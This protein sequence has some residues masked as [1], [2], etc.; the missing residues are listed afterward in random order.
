MT[1]L[2]KVLTLLPELIK[3]AQ[4]I[5]RARDKQVDGS[6]MSR[7]ELKEQLQL[8]KK[9]IDE[10]DEKLLNDMFNSL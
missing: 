5:L 8:V 6:E 1:G 4:S 7:K 9:A 3:L 10:G 2:I